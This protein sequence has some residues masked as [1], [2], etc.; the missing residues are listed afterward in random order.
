[1]SYA[2]FDY[3]TLKKYVPDYICDE[4]VKNHTDFAD[5]SVGDNHNVLSDVRKSDICWIKEP[6]YLN[7]FFDDCGAGAAVAAGATIIVDQTK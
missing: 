1:M 7:L 5:G 2:E 4:I 3:W 6:F